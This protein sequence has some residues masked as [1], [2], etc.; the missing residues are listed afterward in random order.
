M[1]SNKIYKAKETFFQSKINSEEKP[2]E[3]TGLKYIYIT[4]LVKNHT[5]IYSLENGESQ[6]ISSI[7]TS[8]TLQY[9]GKQSEYDSDITLTLQG[10]YIVL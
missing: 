7:S 2:A 10:T 9:F 6:E 3:S 5:S 4:D 1:E 8:T